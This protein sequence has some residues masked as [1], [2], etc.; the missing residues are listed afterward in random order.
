MCGRWG[1]HQKKKDPD[2][3]CETEYVI[4]LVTIFIVKNISALIPTGPPSFYHSSLY[5]F[6]HLFCFPQSFFWKEASKSKM[7]QQQNLRP[8]AF[9]ALWCVFT[10]RTRW[11][12]FTPR[13]D[14]LPSPSSPRHLHPA[15]AL[16]LSTKLPCKPVD[17]RWRMTSVIWPFVCVDCSSMSHVWGFSSFPF[18]C[19][20]LKMPVRS[21]SLVFPQFST[22]FWLMNKAW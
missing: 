2:F 7:L 9:L 11:L 4:Y 1:P 19:I 21:I 13:W 16:V 12:C 8:A 6:Q 22:L 10:P 5:W 18:F 15:F 3:S 14:P 20:T 17:T